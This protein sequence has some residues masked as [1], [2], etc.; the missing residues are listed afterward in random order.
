MV[1]RPHRY[2]VQGIGSRGGG[3]MYLFPQQQVYGAQRMYQ[4]SENAVQRMYQR[5]RNIVYSLASQY[6]GVG[7]TVTTTDR[8]QTSF[9]DTKE[10]YES[11]AAQP[12]D[13]SVQPL[14]IGI[15]SPPKPLI[16]EYPPVA[17]S[18]KERSERLRITLDEEVETNMLSELIKQE[19]ARRTNKR[20]AVQHVYN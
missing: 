5:N 6:Q 12:T 9:F 4:L 20:E 16:P 8:L 10:S 2:I 7:E 17:Y 18:P 11:R 1:C 13:V 19:I 3:A 14:Q 15:L